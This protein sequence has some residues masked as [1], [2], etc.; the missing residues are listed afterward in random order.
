MVTNNKFNFKNKI[1]EI[2]LSHREA[3]CLAYLLKGYS[4]AEIS[5][6]LQLSPRTINAF[7]CEMIVKFD[8]ESKAELLEKILNSPF[9]EYLDELIESHKNSSGNK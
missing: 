8:S 1:Q 7:T 9:T 2:D 4:T 5:K 6:I 3:Q